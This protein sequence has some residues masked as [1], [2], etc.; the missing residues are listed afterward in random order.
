MI[1]PYV[2]ASSLSSRVMS[3]ILT[4]KR[5]PDSFNGFYYKINVMR[6]SPNYPAAHP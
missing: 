4:T 2:A 6:P 1:D 5:P 3:Q